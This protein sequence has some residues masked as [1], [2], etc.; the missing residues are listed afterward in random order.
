[1]KAWCVGLASMA[2]IGR[3]EQPSKWELSLKKD[4]KQLSLA[5]SSMAND[6]NT[7]LCYNA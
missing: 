4:D 3:D 5:T 1:M 7:Q 6:D 2:G